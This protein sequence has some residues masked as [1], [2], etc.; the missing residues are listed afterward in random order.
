MKWGWI[1]LV[2]LAVLLVSKCSDEPSQISTLSSAQ[3]TYAVDGQGKDIVP[4]AILFETAM[5][6][7]GLSWLRESSERRS[8][9]NRIR[10]EQDEQ[11]EADLREDMKKSRNWVVT[12]DGETYK[13]YDVVREEEGDFEDWDDFEP[14]REM[15]WYVVR[16]GYS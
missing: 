12:L 6:G 5:E 2:L 4:E 8:A 3:L 15:Y 10:Y 16:Y 1:I 9:L 14:S 11:D 7:D 13:G